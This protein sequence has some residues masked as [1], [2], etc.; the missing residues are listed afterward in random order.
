M[1]KTEKDIYER[2]TFSC[3]NDHCEES[4]PLKIYVKHLK[5]DCKVKLFAECKFPATHP[6][7]LDKKP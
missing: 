1:C 4:I 5:Q 3:Q 6:R 2:M 7:S